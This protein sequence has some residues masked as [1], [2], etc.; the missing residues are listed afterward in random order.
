[1]INCSDPELQYSPVRGE[2]I[3][4]FPEGGV[5]DQPS[6]PTSPFTPPTGGVLQQPTTT[7]PTTPP[8]LFGRND[9]NVPL[10]G[11]V[12][13]QSAITAATPV[14][15]SLIWPN[16]PGRTYTRRRRRKYTADEY[17]ISDSSAISSTYPWLQS[18]S[19]IY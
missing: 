17:N 15:I 2:D 4:G 8:P 6:S 14:P 10:Q 9:Q 3:T 18:T 11:G 12:F 19:D 5:L 7:T 13:G 1:M 16:S